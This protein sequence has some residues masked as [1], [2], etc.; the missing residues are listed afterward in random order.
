LAVL[1]DADKMR[2]VL[3]N[4]LINAVQSI[5]DSGSIAISAKA[6]RKHVTIAVADTG[7]GISADEL[8]K[9]FSPFYTTKEKGSGLGL[10]VAAKIVEGHRGRIEAESTPGHG[11]VFRIRLPRTGRE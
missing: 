10:A 7:C 2:Q 6:E 5:E 1:A 8:E 11:S 4:V 3:L 9:V